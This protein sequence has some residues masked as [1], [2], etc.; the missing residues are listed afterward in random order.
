VSVAFPGSNTA[1][2][3]IIAFVRM[4]T[5]TQTVSISDT[6]GNAYTQ[7][8]AQVQ[9]A[10][11]SQVHIFYAKKILSGANTVTATFSSTTTITL[12]WPRSLSATRPPPRQIMRQPPYP[13]ADRTP[14]HLP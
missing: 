2:N 5:S 4:S 7:A 14:V 12:G 13:P 1:G 11:G 10:D 9:N 3:L 8:V 6:V